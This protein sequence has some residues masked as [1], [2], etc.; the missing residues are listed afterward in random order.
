VCDGVIIITSDDVFAFTKTFCC[1]RITKDE[2]VGWEIQQ[3]VNEVVQ[4]CMN[5]IIL[6][7]TGYDV[8]VPLVTIY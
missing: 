5:E 4:D 8:T 2:N 3:E 7:V 1:I 6:P